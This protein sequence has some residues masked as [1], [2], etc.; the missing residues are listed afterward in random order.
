MSFNKNKGEKYEQP[1][2]REQGIRKDLWESFIPQTH[3]SKDYKNWIAT[4]DIT[5]CY[6]CRTTHGKVFASTEMV[7]CHL[8]QE[9]YGMKLI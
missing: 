7:T 5:T 3:E 8:P 4:L 2:F 1:V 6:Y 9:E